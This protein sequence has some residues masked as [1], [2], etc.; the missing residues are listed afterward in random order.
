MCHYFG[1]FFK[2]A[3]AQCIAERR[4][5]MIHSSD[6][7]SHLGM[8]THLACKCRTWSWWWKWRRWPRQRYNI[9]LPLTTKALE[10]IRFTLW[11]RFHYEARAYLTLHIGA[12]YCNFFW[13]YCQRWFFL[14]QGCTAGQL[15]VA[16]VLAQGKDVIPIPGRILWKESKREKYKQQKSSFDKANKNPAGGKAHSDLESVRYEFE[17]ELWQVQI[18]L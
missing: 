5:S 17:D 9:L 11:E 8:P 16:W 7:Q 15:A 3:V 10:E 18:L 6:S 14:L 12:E 2:Y 13:A 1:T 4:W